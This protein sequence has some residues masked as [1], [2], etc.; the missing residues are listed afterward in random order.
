MK[1]NDDSD[2]YTEPAS[3]CQNEHDQ[4]PV[5]TISIIAP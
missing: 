5:P 4:I 1:L 3:S 2:S